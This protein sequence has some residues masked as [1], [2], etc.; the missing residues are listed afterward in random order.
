MRR[1]ASR[2]VFLSRSTRYVYSNSSVGSVYCYGGLNAGRNYCKTSGAPT[3]ENPKKA[4][5][6]IEKEKQKNLRHETKSNVKSAPEWNE[7]LG[8]TSEAVVKSERDGDKSVKQ[9]QKESVQNMQ[10]ERKENGD[11]KS[12]KS[13][14]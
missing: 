3:N 10:Q 1:V 7:K 4:A 12:Q 6:Q 5:E 14:K 8:S 11:D 13:K 9:M 2:G